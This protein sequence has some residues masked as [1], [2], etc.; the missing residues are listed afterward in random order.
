MDEKIAL[1]ILEEAIIKVAPE[2]IYYGRRWDEN[3]VERCFAYELYH[4]WSILLDDYFEKNPNEKRLYLNGEI[5]K[6]AIGREKTYPDLVLHSGQ[7]NDRKQLI[8]C[9]IKR[10]ENI[11][12][13]ALVTDLYKLLKYK[14][15]YF[16]GK[17][18]SYDS[19]VFIM[20]GCDLETLKTKV[21]ESLKEIHYRNNKDR[22]K[23]L[24]EI[25]YIINSRNK[26][27]VRC[28]AVFSKHDGFDESGKNKKKLIFENDDLF[29]LLN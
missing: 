13:R 1:N 2:Y 4:Q 14:E 28:I 10:S 24:K 20:I 6:K 19:S 17:P 12:F 16:K 5:P 23:I 25:K 7:D 11:N 8:A 15:L 27:S 3:Q 29:S 21:Q 26:T 9:E 18:I 22:I